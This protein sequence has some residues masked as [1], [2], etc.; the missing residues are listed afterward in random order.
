MKPLFIDINQYSDLNEEEVLFLQHFNELQ[1][2]DW[3][4]EE[5]R[6]FYKQRMFYFIKKS[7]DNTRITFT[8]D[9]KNT[10]EDI[11]YYYWDNS[12]RKE[13]TLFADDEVRKEIIYIIWTYFKARFGV[14]LKLLFSGKEQI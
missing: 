1:F 3:M 7:A 6:R 14:R 2:K 13:L 8:F 11:I 4:Y 10:I 5:D 12:E 9:K